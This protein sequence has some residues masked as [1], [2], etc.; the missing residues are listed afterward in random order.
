MSKII[1]S[2]DV[3]VY[4]PSITSLS[5]I[6]FRISGI[7]VLGLWFFIPFLHNFIFFYL[8]SCQLLY[9]IIFLSIF[10]LIFYLIIYIISYHILNGLRHLFWD[11][12]YLYSMDFLAYFFSIALFLIF[13][14][15]I[16]FFL[17]I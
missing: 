5:S 17:I 4:K 3:T 16:I 1:L 14:I 9:K 12:G 2:P 6:F 7:L 8:L 11:N 10:Y 13:Y 15:N